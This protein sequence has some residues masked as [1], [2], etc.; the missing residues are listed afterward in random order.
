M[1]YVISENM[2]RITVQD[3]DTQE[4]SVIDGAEYYHGGET[5]SIIGNN[6]KL[7]AFLSY[8]GV[9]E[10]ELDTY[11]IKRNV[12]IGGLELKEICRPL[13]DGVRDVASNVAISSDLSYIV[14]FIEVYNTLNLFEFFKEKGYVRFDI[15][16]YEHLPNSDWAYIRFK[17]PQFCIKELRRK[18]EDV[19]TIVE[20]NGE[21]DNKSNLY[22]GD[23]STYYNNLV[24]QEFADTTSR[25][26]NK[27][28]TLNCG[29]LI[30]EVSLNFIE[31]KT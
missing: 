11:Y 18:V 20:K 4:I 7:N 3:I 26:L 1:R 13:G 21:E 5:G 24:R 17:L 19:V 8:D 15:L 16:L 25:I 23:L 10:D 29:G 22:N 9:R 30:F 14:Y 28:V 27:D 2:R 31:P 12:L 6:S